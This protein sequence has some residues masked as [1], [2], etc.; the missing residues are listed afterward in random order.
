MAR[1]F[2]KACTRTAGSGKGFGALEDDLANCMSAC[3]GLFPAQLL[4][5]LHLKGRY[6]HQRYMR[7]TVLMLASVKRPE[8]NRHQETPRLHT[9]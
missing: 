1:S 5:A 2:V 7:S 3:L 8:D 9:H 4:D 6:C